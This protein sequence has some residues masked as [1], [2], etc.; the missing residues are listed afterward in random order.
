AGDLRSSSRRTIPSIFTRRPMRILFSVRLPR[1]L[2]TSCSDN[3][4]C[5]PALQR[6]V[7]ANGGST[8]SNNGWRTVD[9]F[10]LRRQHT[11]EKLIGA[12]AWDEAGLVGDLGE[13]GQF[14]GK[15]S[16]PQQ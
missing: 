4:R 13:A 5:T 3:T 8:R 15:R 9:D 16:K 12:S 6:C 11:N 10:E 2:T 1:T 7:R 14:T